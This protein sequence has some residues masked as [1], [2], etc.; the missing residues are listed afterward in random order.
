M[1]GAEPTAA[2]FRP[3]VVAWRNGAPVRMED[4]AKVEDSVEN[5]AG[6]CRVRRRPLHHPVDPAPARCQHGRR[7]R[8]DSQGRI[9]EFQR[10]LPPTI[11]LS[12]LSDRSESIRASVHDVQITLILTAVLVIL[13]IL[14]FLRTWRATFIPAHRVA[15]VDHRH[16]RAAWR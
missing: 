2:F 16:V 15:A 9:P 8:R 5:D 4:I 6:A 13:V 14:A 10:L 12:V 3:L 11:K 1:A 7:H